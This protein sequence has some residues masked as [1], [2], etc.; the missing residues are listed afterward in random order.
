MEKVRALATFIQVVDSGSF[1]TAG[2]QLGVSSSAVGKAISRLE[3]RLG[4]RLFLRSTRSLTLTPEGEVFLGR[5]RRILAE[6]ELAEEEIRQ[7]TE[8]PIGRLKVSLPMF[9]DPF[10]TTLAE[11]QLAHPKVEVDVHFA[12]RKVEL[13][14]EGFDVALRSGDIGNSYLMSRRLGSF[15][16][17]VVAAPSYLSEFGEPALP[18]DLEQ[19]TCIG[20][21]SPATGRIQPWL[22]EVQGSLRPHHP[23]VR[24]VCNSIEGRIAFAASGVGLAYLPDFSVRRLVD[25]NVLKLVMNDFATFR[26]QI[27]LLWS[28]GRNPPPRTRAFIDFIS[29][30]LHIGK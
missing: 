15:R 10:S 12:D 2:R 4:A 18:E 3:D 22:L 17:V 19:H 28:A 20:F 11:F 24:T 16:M 23:V 29:S 5:C 7:S 9:G 8:E 14:E 21:R 6:F 1:V 25:N 13:I 30:N 27:H 26:N